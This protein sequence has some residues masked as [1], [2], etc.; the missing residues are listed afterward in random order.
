MASMTV[1]KMRLSA[2][3][4]SLKHNATIA[5]YTGKPLRAYEKKDPVPFQKQLDELERI[6]KA[7]KSQ[8]HFSQYK[9]RFAGDREGRYRAQQAADQHQRDYEEIERICNELAADVINQYYHQVPV[10]DQHVLK[11]LLDL[12]KHGKKFNEK[13]SG[14][15]KLAGKMD[16]TTTA[17]IGPMIRDARAQTGGAGQVDVF[18]S[19]NVLIIVFYLVKMSLKA[20]KDSKK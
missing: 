6:L 12:V 3:R 17:T 20:S 15:E 19:L 1:L 14:V 4:Q 10:Q 8:S 5:D 11:N 7:A 2:M 9:V 18:A 16:K 13:L